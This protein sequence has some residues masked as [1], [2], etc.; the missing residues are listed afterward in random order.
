MQADLQFMSFWI[1][2]LVI[3]G[4]CCLPMI[5][6]HSGH[7]WKS[8]KM[9]FRVCVCGKAAPVPQPQSGRAFL[10]LAVCDR[11]G[12]AGISSAGLG[13]QRSH[14]QGWGS[15]DHISPLS[16]VCVEALGALCL[17]LLWLVR[18]FS[19]CSGFVAQLC[20]E[21]ALCAG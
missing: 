6:L 3:T 13:E 1:N 8:H 21:L 15:T 16:K 4:H 11:A 7:S 9:T 10:L 5:M 12:G 20:S 19:S 18:G 14:Q 2:I 17:F